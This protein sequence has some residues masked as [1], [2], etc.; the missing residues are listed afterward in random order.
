MNTIFAFDSYINDEEQTLIL[1]TN[2]AETLEFETWD[3]YHL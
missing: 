2:I 1:S 3:K